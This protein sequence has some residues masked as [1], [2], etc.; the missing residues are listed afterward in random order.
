MNERTVIESVRKGHLLTIAQKASA[1]QAACM[2]TKANTGSIVV[3]D[4]SGS[5]LGILTE[6][7]VMAKVVSRARQAEKT[8]VS[9]IMTRN[10]RYVSPDTSVAEAVLIMKNGGFRHLP[11]L[12][13]G[14]VVA[15][16][17]MRDASPDEMIEADRQAEQIDRVSESL[18]Y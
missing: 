15:M 5:M 18:G 4:T 11:I 2:M 1:Y 16:F 13:K 9:E 7:D 17:S 14:K 12:S 10:P 6:R 8:S 3:A